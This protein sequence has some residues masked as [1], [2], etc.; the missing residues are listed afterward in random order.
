MFRKGACYLFQV[1]N[2]LGEYE[3][4]VDISPLWFRPK[5]SVL[6]M[7]KPDQYLQ[8]IG[9]TPVEKLVL[10]ENMIQ[11]DVFSTSPEGRPYGTEEFLLIDTESLEYRGI[12]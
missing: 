1:I 9:H 8:V 2:G 11:C 4:W 12:R 7:Y 10:E 6:K 3:M 5:D